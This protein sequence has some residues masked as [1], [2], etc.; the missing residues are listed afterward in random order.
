VIYKGAIYRINFFRCINEFWVPFF[1]VVP[2][3]LVMGRDQAIFVTHSD[4][5]LHGGLNEGPIPPYWAHDPMSQF[6]APS[7]ESSSCFY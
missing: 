3:A 1:L 7:S 4:W 5:R 2:A 6:V